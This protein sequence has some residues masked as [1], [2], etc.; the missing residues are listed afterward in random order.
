MKRINCKYEALLGYMNTGGKFFHL[1]F[2]W[3]QGEKGA[4]GLSDKVRT[5]LKKKD[6]SI[7][8]KLLFNRDTP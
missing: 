5:Y 1:F 8:Q 3:H 4:N 6:C 2:S 7:F